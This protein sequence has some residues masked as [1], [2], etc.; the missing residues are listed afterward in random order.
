ML[1]SETTA[2]FEYLGS[3]FTPLSILCARTQRVA[4]NS[5]GFCFIY[6]TIFV[7][8]NNLPNIDH[9]YCQLEVFNSL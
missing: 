1:T 7:N 4:K 6:R 8:Y 9:I 3:S 2:Y 5:D